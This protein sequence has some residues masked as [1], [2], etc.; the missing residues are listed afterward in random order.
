MLFENMTNDQKN[1][2]HNFYLRATKMCEDR[3]NEL[4]KKRHFA[5]AIGH[6]SYRI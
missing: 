3:N 5:S 1:M 4:S 6:N 2:A